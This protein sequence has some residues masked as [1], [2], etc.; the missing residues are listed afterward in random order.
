MRVE[1][2]RGFQ[3]VLLAGV[4]LAGA[5]CAPSLW[6]RWQGSGER[7]EG[8]LFQVALDLQKKGSSAVWLD[9]R[10]ATTRLAVCQVQQGEEGEVQF[11]IDPETPAL[12][13]SEMRHPWTVRARMGGHVLVG[14]LV[15]AAGRPEGRFRALRSE[16]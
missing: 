4:C 2:L 15:D 10:G 12:E 8:R 14:D 11:Q 3:W 6:D 16:R 1:T 13:C 5:G 7:F 9:E